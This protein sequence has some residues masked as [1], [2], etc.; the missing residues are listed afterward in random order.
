MA[1]DADGTFHDGGGDDLD[2]GGGGGEVAVAA[3]GDLDGDAAGGG[4]GV[5]EGLVRSEGGGLAFYG[6]GDGFIR[7]GGFSGE[8][9][10]LE[11]I[12][13]ADAKDARKNKCCFLIWKG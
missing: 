1:D 12:A 6:E 7:S 2:G 8:G 3:V 13:E 11:G 10:E 4:E 9:G 5:D